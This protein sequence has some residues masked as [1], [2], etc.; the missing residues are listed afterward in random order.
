MALMYPPGR[1]KKER[2]FGRSFPPMSRTARKQGPEGPTPALHGHSS[3]FVLICQAP[4][5]IAKLAATVSGC[6]GL[7]GSPGGSYPGQREH[8]P[9]PLFT[10]APRPGTDLG[11]EPKGDRNTGLAPNQPCAP[12]SPQRGRRGGGAQGRTPD[13]HRSSD[14]GTQP[15]GAGRR[16][17]PGGEQGRRTTQPGA[18]A[19]PPPPGTN[20]PAGDQPERR[21][22][23]RRGGRG[24]PQNQAR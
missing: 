3:T 2:P 10:C 24:P 19:P 16:E 12:R 9:P 1:A 8:L 6:W 17:R 7:P 5:L 22:R 21:T 4:V 14:R 18:G 11:A 20:R 13:K 15:H 23:Q